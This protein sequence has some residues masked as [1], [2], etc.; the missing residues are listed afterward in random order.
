MQIKQLNSIDEQM[1]TNKM[2]GSEYKK[3]GVKEQG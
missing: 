3:D 2:K 1:M